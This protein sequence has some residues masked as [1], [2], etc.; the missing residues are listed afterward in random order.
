MLNCDIGKSDRLWLK[1]LLEALGLHIVRFGAI[2][3]S[4]YAAAPVLSQFD[5]IPTGERAHQRL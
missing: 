4:G 5:F 3:D 1:P 2:K